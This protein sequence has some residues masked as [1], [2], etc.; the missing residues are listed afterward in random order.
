MASNPKPTVPADMKSNVAGDLLVQ[1]LFRKTQYLRESLSP[2]FTE[3][4]RQI[5]EEAFVLY[6]LPLF[7]GD[8]SKD[9]QK[10]TEAL[11][12]WFRVAGSPYAAVSI[13]ALGQVVAVVPPVR[14]NVLS[15]KPLEVAQDLNSVFI[16]AANL[17]TL[18]PVGARNYV[19]QQLHDRYIKAIPKPD[20]TVDQRAWFDLLNH[21]G[22]APKELSAQVQKDPKA[23][24]AQEDDFEF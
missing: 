24:Q 2:F 9:K 1:D 23:T 5:D 8:Y 19:T 11:A 4:Q 10:Y 22:K 17:E 13:I 15:G 14:N 16:Q 20:L 21:Y 3:A 7:A 18:S 12:G 6:F